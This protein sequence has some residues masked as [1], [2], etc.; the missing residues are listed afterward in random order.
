MALSKRDFFDAIDYSNTA[1]EIHEYLLT[2][3]KTQQENFA[4]KRDV[5]QSEVLSKISDIEFR[6]AQLDMLSAVYRKMLLNT[7]G[8]I[9]GCN[10]AELNTI[11]SGLLHIVATTLEASVNDFGINAKIAVDIKEEKN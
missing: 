4:K 7:L 10:E 11:K 3:L 1:V 8:E 2:T 9:E 5:E 6:F